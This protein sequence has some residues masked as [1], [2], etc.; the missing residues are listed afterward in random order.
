MGG[1]YAY[2]VEEW[3]EKTIGNLASEARFWYYR[4]LEK[5]KEFGIEFLRARLESKELLSFAMAIGQAAVDYF[6]AI[7]SLMAFPLKNMDKLEFITSTK[8]F[9]PEVASLLRNKKSDCV[10]DLLTEFLR[11]KI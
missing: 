11:V 10:Y 4:A 8:V 6:E 5:A 2:I 7:D 1:A 3:N 9:L